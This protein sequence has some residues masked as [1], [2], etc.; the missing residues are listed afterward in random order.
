ME[1]K[2]TK[3]RIG[4]VITLVLFVFSIGGWVVDRMVFQTRIETKLETLIEN[5]KNTEA[6]KDDQ[7]EFNGKLLIIMEIVTDK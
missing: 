2:W 4:F 5:S 6:F 3:E 7:R 1:K